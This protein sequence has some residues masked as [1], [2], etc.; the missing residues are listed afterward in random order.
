MKKWVREGVSK[1]DAI[2]RRP[3]LVQKRVVSIVTLVALS[4]VSTVTNVSPLNT[5]RQIL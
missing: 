5:C 3:T 2:S 1:T 4:R